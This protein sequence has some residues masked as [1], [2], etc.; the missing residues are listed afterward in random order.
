M[1][2]E[3][4]ARRLIGRATREREYMDKYGLGLKVVS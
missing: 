2:N 3:C 1:C 4:H